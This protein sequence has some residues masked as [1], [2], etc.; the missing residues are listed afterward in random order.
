MLDA[1]GLRPDGSGPAQARLTFTCLVL[2]EPRFERLA[3]LMQRQLLSVDVDMRL[4]AL[5]RTEFATRVASGRF[6]AFLAS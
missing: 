1:A 6:D 3:L 4:E 2:A 5:P